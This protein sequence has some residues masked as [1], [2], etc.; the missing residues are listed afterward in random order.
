VSAL[1]GGGGRGGA[2]G[3][4]KKMETRPPA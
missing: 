4:A 3:Q 1:Y 2:P